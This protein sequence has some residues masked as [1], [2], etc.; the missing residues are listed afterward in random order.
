MPLDRDMLAALLVRS[1]TAPAAL[2]EA[3]ALA[4]GALAPL[5][6]KTISRRAVHGHA[7][8]LPRPL[9]DLEDNDQVVILS[10]F[11]NGTRSREVSKRDRVAASLLRMCVRAQEAGSVDAVA[12]AQIPQL[13]ERLAAVTETHASVSRA[14]A[15]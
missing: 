14:G 5:A 8:G 12:L 15:R 13:L 11:V 9:V 2:A 3:R 10:V 1:D 4:A 7:A 6:E